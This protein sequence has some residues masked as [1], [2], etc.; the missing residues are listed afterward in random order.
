MS[1]PM[2]NLHFT[3]TVLILKANADTILFMF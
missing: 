1:E 3:Y 2:D